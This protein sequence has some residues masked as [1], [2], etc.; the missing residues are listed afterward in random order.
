M[1]IKETIE[2]IHRELCQN[3][4]G[5]RK[6]EIHLPAQ[7]FFSFGKFV[8]FCIR[9][10]E[11]ETKRHLDVKKLKRFSVKINGRKVNFIKNVE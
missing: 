7:T 11:A 10:N 9:N 2:I 1:T 3:V 5:K 8:Q 4:Y 6:I